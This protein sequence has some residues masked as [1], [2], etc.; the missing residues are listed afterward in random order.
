MGAGYMEAEQTKNICLCG[1]QV[2][3][4]LERQLQI[5]GGLYT[6]NRKLLCN[7]GTKV[8]RKGDKNCWCVEED[9]AI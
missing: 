2:T 4:G 1:A 9:C 3:T 7:M 6:T 5:V 8:S